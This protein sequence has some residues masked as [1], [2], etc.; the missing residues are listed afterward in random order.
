M[1]EEEVWQFI[2]KRHE[3]YHANLKHFGYGY[4]SFIP[5]TK[6]I[7]EMFSK[8]TLSE[9][10]IK[11]YRESIAKTYNVEQLKRLDGLFADDVKPK[12]VNVAKE[13][14]SPLISSW[15][16]VLPENL[17]ILCTYGDGGSYYVSQDGKYAQITLRM[18]RMQEDK[19]RLFGLLMHEFIH[20][21]IQRQIIAKYHVPQDLKERIVDIIGSELFQIPVQSKFENSF[22]NTYIT[23]ESIKTD[24]PGAVA[25]MMA[26]YI[27][28]KQNNINGR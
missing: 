5:R 23:P 21:L 28:L 3:S 13:V 11:K 25:K 9:Q 2:L 27:V 14:L 12:I 1:T 26:D 7:Y 17:E 24:L 8:E 15:D 22:A 6:S 18:S 10:D 16:A 19:N 20:I 4:S